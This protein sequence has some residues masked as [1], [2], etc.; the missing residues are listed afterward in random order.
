MKLVLFVVM[1]FI[2]M[3]SYAEIYKCNVNGKYS[4]QST[5]CDNGVVFKL[6][7]ELSKKDQQKAAILLERDLGARARR[8]ELNNDKRDKERLIRASEVEANATVEQAR[9]QAISTEQQR[10]IELRKKPV[11]I[12]PNSKGR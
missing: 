6:K 11:F 8:I 5:A 3:S 12:S 9:Q 10:K 7:K 4:F 1:T 2:S